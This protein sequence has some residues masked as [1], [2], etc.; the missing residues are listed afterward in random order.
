MRCGSSARRSRPRRGRTSSQLLENEIRDA[1]ADF[2]V[3]ELYA[4]VDV[5]A[6]SL[7]RLPEEFRGLA[8][9]AAGGL[10]QAATAGA[11]RAL[12]QPRVQAAWENANRSR[13]RTCSRCSTTSK[14][15]R[16]R[17]ASS[18]S[19][20]A[21]SSRP[22][23]SRSGSGATSRTS[24]RRAAELEILR[25]DELSAAQNGAELLRILA[26]W[27]TAITLLLYALAIYLARGWRREALRTVGIAL[28][29]VGVLVLFAHGLA[30]NA[31]V[32]ALTETATSEGPVQATWDIA[33]SLLVA[34]GQAIIAYGVVIVL[35][36]WLAGPSA[37]AT[38]VR[39]G[40]TP[41]LR[42]PRFAYAGLAVLLAL[43]FWWNPT[44]ATRRLPTSILLIVLLALG[45]EVLRR[46]V[47]REFSDRVTMWSPEAT[48]RALAERMRERRER[49]VATG[50]AVAS[51]P[52]DQ[53]LAQLEA[54]PP[55]R[56]RG[57]V[58]ARRR[59]AAHPR[60]D[61]HRVASATAPWS[62][63]R[64]RKPVLLAVDDEP[65]TL[66]RIER[67]L[68]RRYAGD[69]RIVCV[70][71]GRRRAPSSTRCARP[72]R[73]RRRA[74]RPV[75]ARSHRDRVPGTGGGAVPS[76]SG[77]CSSN[78]GRGGT[79]RRPTRSCAR[80]RWGRSTTTC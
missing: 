63:G 45:V 59:E 72:R 13:T 56:V 10:R 47:I 57:A 30:G 39:R 36:A 61:S 19:T 62:W 71:S 7:Q 20:C 41:Y 60:V 31:V 18:R 76:A 2:L 52:D 5:E 33:T 75:A 53:R 73:R 80:W 9:L 35:A 11:Q 77:R 3:A 28:V 55:A 67:E 15:R 68:V 50:T 17:E 6:R 64:R 42:Q 12:E 46:Q 26:F 58:D 22:S 16:P 25:S 70:E 48:A 32:G 49:R 14:G 23:A 38:W 44:E 51:S 8:G 4:N 1:V 21:R 66:G 74:R 29:V 69:Y 34:T 54:R 78:G 40:I 27:L 24:L 79:G 43:L 65:D 37:A